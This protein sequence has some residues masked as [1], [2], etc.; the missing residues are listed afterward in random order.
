MYNN[1]KMSQNGIYFNDNIRRMLDPENNNG[2]YFTPLTIRFKLVYTTSIRFYTV[3]P[4]WTTRELYTF[5]RPYVSIDFE[6]ENFDIVLAGQSE[7]E[8]AEALRVSSNIRI[9]HFM[10]GLDGETM[11]I[12]PR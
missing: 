10:S 9:S 4:D 7:S 5:I 1:Y 12:R 11:Y 6:L 2:T 8:E 3:C